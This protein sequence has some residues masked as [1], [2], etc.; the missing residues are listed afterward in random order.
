MADAV[1]VNSEILRWARE[2]AHLTLHDAASKIGLSEEKLIK[3]EGDEV[4]PSPS[5]LIRMADAYRRPLVTFYMTKP[6]RTAE[7]VGD[8][9]TTTGT[10]PAREKALLDALVRDIR[11]RQSIARDLLEN[12]EDAG[13]LNFV[14]SSSTEDGIHS[15]VSR[16]RDVLA[17]AHGDQK[18]AKDPGALFKLL[19]QRAEDAGVFVLLAGDLGSPQHNAISVETF[20]GYALVDKVAPFVVINDRDAKAAWNFTLIH[21]L[22]HILV[23][24]EGISAAVDPDAAH[25][26][27]YVE[28]FCN[29]VASEF[30]LPE[31]ELPNVDVEL[32]L[33]EEYISELI[34]KAADYW[35]VS[36]L[37]VAYRLYKT[38]K[39]EQRLWISLRARHKVEYEKVKERGKRVGKV[40]GPS[41]YVVRRDR[42]GKRLLNLAR[43]TI[44]SGALSYTTAAKLLAVK[45]SNVVPLLNDGH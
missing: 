3:I 4:A 43:Q 32:A 31:A 44:A 21:E 17:V 9:R 45:A 36:R 29:Q 25:L 7:P 38:K 41:Y 26:L 5:L 15:V 18:G 13:E 28:V 20:R 24:A 10:S 22:A 34:D 12:D 39:I 8:F 11:A 19:R 6:P 40:G 14:S 23:G 35:N 30:L 1:A 42:L 2:S 33:D 37:A 27:P 16:L